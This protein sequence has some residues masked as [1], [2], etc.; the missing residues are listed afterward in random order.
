MRVRRAVLATSVAAA[1]ALRL[2]PA[3]AHVTWFQPPQG[4][5]ISPEAVLQWPSLLGLAV[6]G[7]AVGVAW[8]ADWLLRRAPWFPPAPEALGV[9]RQRLERLYAWLPLLLATHL[10]VALLALAMQLQLLAPHLELPESFLGGVLALGE[11]VVGLALLYGAFSR[12]AAVGLALLV[13]AALPLFGPV[14]ALEQLH[15]L[16]IAA[17]FFLLGRGPFSLD[18]LLGRSPRTAPRL[19]RY[20]VPLLR[21]LTGLG[22]AFTGFTEKLWNLPPGPGLH[23]FQRPGLRHPGGSIRGGPGGAAGVGAAHAA[24]GAGAPL[25]LQPHPTLP[26]PARTHRAPA[27]LRHPGHPPHLRRHRRLPP[28]RPPPGA[29]PAPPPREPPGRARHAGRPR[30]DA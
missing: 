14:R 19:R 3:H 9:S 1:L 2:A 18:G 15:Y 30:D 26:G 21:V 4:Y 8:L 16:G 22:I 20:A 5:P 27:H 7:L 23:R 11:I 25:P 10:A 24:G 13:A 29:A 17:F 12:A 6:A 28:G